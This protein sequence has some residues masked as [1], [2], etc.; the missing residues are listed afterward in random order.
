MG[1]IAAALGE[2]EFRVINTAELSDSQRLEIH[3]LFSRNYQQP[4]QQYLDTSLKTLRSMSLA[5]DGEQLVGFSLA[6]SRTL[7]LPRMEAEQFVV[8]GGIGCIDSRYRRLGLFSHLANLAGGEMG[9]LFD[10]HERVLACARIAHPASFRTLRRLPGVVPSEAA[11]LSEWHLE[12]GVAVAN[13]YGVDLKPGTLIV[14]GSGTPIGYSNIEM[15]VAE[16]EWEVFAGVD[17][18]RGDS[19]LGL[20]WAPDSPSG[21]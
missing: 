4:N 2:L 17:R 3:D 21:W 20:A 5:L 13:L 16:E 18:D 15:D 14:K 9:P 12:V 8:L 1:S 7:R 10:Q 11:E 19:L 6:D